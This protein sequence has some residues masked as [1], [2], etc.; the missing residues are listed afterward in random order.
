MDMLD[1]FVAFLGRQW[2]IV[3]NGFE[4]GAFVADCQGAEHHA[5]K[6]ENGRGHQQQ[7]ED[8]RYA[9][10][11]PG[12]DQGCQG[13]GIEEVMPAA[14]LGVVVGRA[15]DCKSWRPGERGPVLA[16]AG[17]ATT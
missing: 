8:G 3:A 14:R 4:P 9:A 17:V 15:R 1:I 6:S 13:E 2:E 16:K 12:P 5:A 7:G 11:W 10:D